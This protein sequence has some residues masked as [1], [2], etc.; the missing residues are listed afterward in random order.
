MVLK[1]VTDLESFNWL[2]Y[3]TEEFIRIQ[4]AKFFIEIKQSADVKSTTE[5]WQIRQKKL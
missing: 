3:I 4:D 5:G 1:I 2:N